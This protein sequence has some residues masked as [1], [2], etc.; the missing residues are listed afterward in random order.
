MSTKRLYCVGCEEFKDNPENS[1]T[2]K[3]P[4]H[5]KFRMEKRENLF[6]RLS[7]Y[8]EEIENIKQPSSL[9]HKKEGMKL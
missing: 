3:C 9:S 8:Q 2:Y 4:I 6:F 7:K 5:Q 1:S